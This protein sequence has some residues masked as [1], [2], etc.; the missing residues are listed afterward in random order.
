MLP[1][2]NKHCNIA[3]SSH[4]VSGWLARKWGGSEAGP[5]AP[6]RINRVGSLGAVSYW[7]RAACGVWWCSNGYSIVV[8]NRGLPYTA[9]FSSSTLALHQEAAALGKEL[10]GDEHFTLRLHTLYPHACTFHIP[11]QTATTWLLTWSYQRS[12]W[13]FIQSVRRRQCASHPR[14]PSI[15]W[16]VH[17]CWIWGVGVN[18][19][20]PVRSSPTIVCLEL[21]CFL[22]AWLAPPCCSQ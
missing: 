19:C 8:T 15:L 21:C 13:Y 12:L 11:S 6:R 3:R 4:T 18:V 22:S 10:G 14:R 2:A 16:W 20:V 17:V 7:C 1:A 5:I 9:P